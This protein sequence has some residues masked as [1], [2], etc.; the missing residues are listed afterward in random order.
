MFA[1]AL[2]HAGLGEIGNLLRST[3]RA[4][5][6]TVR[7]AERNHFALAIF[8]ICEVDYRLLK[9][10][11]DVHVLRIRLFAW[12]V[13]YIIAQNRVTLGGG[14]INLSVFPLLSGGH[15]DCGLRSYTPT[16][17]TPAAGSRIPPGTSG[18]RTPR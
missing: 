16:L 10:F 18:E 1:V 9:C 5:H 7:P 15:L 13:K 3:G 11:D 17:Q 4:L 2:P 6:H 14:Y 8:V 12:S